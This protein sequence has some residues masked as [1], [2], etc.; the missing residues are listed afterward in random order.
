MSFAIRRA[1][2]R[3]PLKVEVTLESEDNFYSGV[4]NDV[5]EGGVFVACEDPPAVGTTVELDLTVPTSEHPFHVTGV[6]RWVREDWVAREGAPAGCGIEWVAISDDAV[7]AI[8]KF[9][10]ESRDTILYEAAY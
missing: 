6:V 1:H 3:A 7:A 2:E 4:A 10:R 8:A 5:S 9:V